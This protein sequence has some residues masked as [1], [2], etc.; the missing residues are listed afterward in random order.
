[1]LENTDTGRRSG[2]TIN[3]GRTPLPAPWAKPTRTSNSYRREI[4]HVSKDGQTVF[5]SGKWSHSLEGNFHSRRFFSEAPL[6]RGIVIL[7]CDNK[8]QFERSV[9]SRSWALTRV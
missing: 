7:A 3:S 5:G 6:L 2:R 1:M 8:I 4:L 9:L